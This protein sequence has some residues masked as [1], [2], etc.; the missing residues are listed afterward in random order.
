MGGRWEGVG[1]VVEG[2]GV[3]LKISMWLIGSGLAQRPIDTMEDKNCGFPA[4]MSGKPMCIIGS[5]KTNLR[6]RDG[7]DGFAYGT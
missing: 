1:D 3:D 2:V 5:G 7:E 4:A 6:P